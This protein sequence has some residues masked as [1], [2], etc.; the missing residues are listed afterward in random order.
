MRASWRVICPIL[1]RSCP[2]HQE[3]QHRAEAGVGRRSLW[4][5]F[6]RRVL[7]P[8]ARPGEDPRG[9]QGADRSK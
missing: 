9:S 4:E 3:T 1:R 8:D 2:T 7:Q 5:G 6:P